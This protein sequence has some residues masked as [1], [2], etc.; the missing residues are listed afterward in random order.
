[1]QFVQWVF[2]FI[3]NY[4]K[5]QKASHSEGWLNVFVY[6]S[7]AEQRVVALSR[8]QCCLQFETDD[9]HSDRRMEVKF[10]PPRNFAKKL[11]PDPANISID[12]CRDFR[13]IAL[14][15]NKE[16]V[17]TQAEKRVGNLRP[18]TR[19]KIWDPTRPDLRFLGFRLQPD[20]TWTR[21]T[22]NAL[23]VKARALTA[24]LRHVS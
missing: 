12:S 5:K 6:N 20:P 9:E 14:R 19:V 24:R 13:R 2:L 7:G 23:T 8:R 1:M 16:S 3:Q 4:T 22:R 21:K 15:L 18:D 10:K 11:S 17:A